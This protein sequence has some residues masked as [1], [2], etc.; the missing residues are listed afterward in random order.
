MSIKNWFA[1]A[2]ERIETRVETS[3]PTNADGK[4]T[5]GLDEPM[6]WGRVALWLGVLVAFIWAAFAPLG[7]GIPA[8]GTVKVEG[9]RK[10]VQ[11]PRGGVIDQ[12]LVREGDVVQA[13]QA[14]IRM[15]DS[16]AQ[17]QH[18]IVDSQLISLY[19]TEARLKAERGDKDSIEFP[20]FLRERKGNAQVDEA[21]QAQQQLFRTRQ[22]GLRGEIAIA[23]ENISGLE[24]QIRGL[25]EQEKS[26]NEQLRLFKEELDSLRPLHEQGFVPRNRMFELERAVAFLGGQRSEDSAN[27]GRVKSQIAELKLKILQ[28]REAYRKEVETLLSEVQRQLADYKERRIATQDDLQRVVLKAPVAGTVVDLTV[29]TVGGVVDAGQKLMDIVPISQTL[30]I[31]ARIPTHLIDGVRVGQEADVQFPALNQSQIP[32]VQ[33]KLIYIAADSVTDQRTGAPYFVGRV[34]TT[35]EGMKKLGNNTIQ[36]G[37]PANVVIKTGERSLLSYLL[38]PLLARLQ[39]AFTER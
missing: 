22:A 3:F 37:M 2:R 31:E 15:N 21:R 13:G 11:H 17:A 34:A 8:Q 35:P 27:L 19:A 28:V 16:M 25:V 18:G 26:K 4:T 32:T 5:I 10:S 38:K 29:H 7:Q 36:A 14:L 33:G 30:I 1:G 39:F 23:R 20:E 6:R 24:E 12:I 9:E